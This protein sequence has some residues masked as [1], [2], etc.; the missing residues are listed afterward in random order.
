MS[1]SESYEKGPEMRRRLLG[2]AFIA[3][4]VSLALQ[5][6]NPGLFAEHSASSTIS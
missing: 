2:D 1:N 4:A 6:V 5:A 3:H